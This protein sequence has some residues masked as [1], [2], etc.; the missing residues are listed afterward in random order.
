M[1]REGQYRRAERR[2][3]VWK[4]AIESERREQMHVSQRV[5]VNQERVGASEPERKNRREGRR[6]SERASERESR[7]KVSARESGKIRGREE[8][9]ERKSTHCS[10]SGQICS[11]AAR[12]A[13]W[14]RMRTASMKARAAETVPEKLPT[15]TEGQGVSYTTLPMAVSATMVTTAKARATS[16]RRDSYRTRP[17][18]RTRSPR[19]CCGCVE[20]S[21]D[22][23]VERLILS[24]VGNKT[25]RVS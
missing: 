8:G 1:E 16:A 11:R 4:R 24:Q 25:S 14:R 22:H 12:R 21:K 10:S 5:G 18:E 6:A 23:G 13:R 2:E 15:T 19:D 17:T 7:E 20:G 3:S 9:E